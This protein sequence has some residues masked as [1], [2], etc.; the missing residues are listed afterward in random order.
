MAD[1]LSDAVRRARAESVLIPK[2]VLVERMTRNA[3]I[4]RTCSGVD[5]DVVRMADE[6][7]Q[8]ASSIQDEDD[9]IGCVRKW[10]EISSTTS[11]ATRDFSSGLGSLLMRIGV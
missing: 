8:D 10:V 3:D 5:P 6:A 7:V 9:V 1:Q 2:A 4:L 11:D